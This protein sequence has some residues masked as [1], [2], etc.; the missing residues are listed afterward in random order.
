MRNTVTSHRRNARNTVFTHGGLRERG[1]SHDGGA[2]T[3][4]ARGRGSPAPPHGHLRTAHP[5][6]PSIGVREGEVFRVASLNRVRVS[7]GGRFPS[8]SATGNGAGLAQLLKSCRSRCFTPGD[9]REGGA[10]AASHR[11]VICPTSVRETASSARSR[12][13]G[14]TIRRNPQHA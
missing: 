14:R 2:R 9:H 5:V 4:L 12:C 7:V 8:T 11:G 13:A 3:S 1:L 6:R 10:L